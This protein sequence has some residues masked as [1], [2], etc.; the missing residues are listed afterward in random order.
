MTGV[1]TCALPIWTSDVERFAA[2][3]KDSARREREQRKAADERAA[4]ARAEAQQRADHDAALVSARRDLDRAIAGVRSA[5][6]AAVA[7]AEAAWRA[8][9]ARVI[10][11]ETGAP[12]A[13]AKV[14][15]THDD[16]VADDGADESA[17][18]EGDAAS[19]D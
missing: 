16:A 10:E 8:A 3:M 14:T 1:Q 18:V 12:P 4:V 9:K 17:P 11:L 6:G 19:S 5:S 7:A 15:A 2:A 13:W